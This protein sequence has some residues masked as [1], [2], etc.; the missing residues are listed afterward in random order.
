MFDRNFTINIQPVA[1]WEQNGPSDYPRFIINTTT[2]IG[3]DN[4]SYG[5]ALTRYLWERTFSWPVTTNGNL[6]GLGYYNVCLG[7]PD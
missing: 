3:P 7:K 2:T 5:A 6:G 4:M 1:N